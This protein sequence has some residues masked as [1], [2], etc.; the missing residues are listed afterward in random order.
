MG[1]L[2]GSALDST[3]G[4]YSAPSGPLA[5]ISNILLEINTEMLWEKQF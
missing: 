2:P 3:G 4:A 5:E 1:W